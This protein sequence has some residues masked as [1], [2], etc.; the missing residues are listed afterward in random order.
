MVTSEEHVAARVVEHVK[1]APPKHQAKLARART[2]QQNNHK[3]RR[4]KECT[5]HAK[6]NRYERKA[7]KKIA[8]LAKVCSG[9]AQPRGHSPVL[10]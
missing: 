4:Q 3:S 7:E 6:P 2:M 10:S 5:M 9:R 1:K 8:R